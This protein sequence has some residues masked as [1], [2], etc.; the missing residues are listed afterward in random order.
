MALQAQDFES[1]RLALRARCPGLTA[2]DID[3]AFDERQLVISWLGR[4]TLHLVCA[5]DWAW[6][7]SLSAPR[8]LAGNRRRLAEEGVTADDADRALVVIERA[9]ADCGPSTR[10]DLR[11][12]VAAAGVRSEGQ[13]MVHLL[14]LAAFGGRIVRCDRQRY[15]LAADWLPVSPPVDRDAA[16]WELGLRYR[17]AHALAGPRDLAWWAGISLGEARIAWRDTSEPDTDSGPLDPK[18]LASFDE[19]VLGWK[20]RSFAIPERMRPQVF[21]G[22]IIRAVAT[23]DGEVVDTWTR[24]SGRVRLAD[25]DHAALFADEARD[26]ERFLA[27]T[28]CEND[29]PRD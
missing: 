18:L 12:L 23:V 21:A 17:A 6:L 7:L 13:A 25:G 4:G 22:G 19:Y 8:Q 29:P 26:V 27:G 10:E 9:L 16:L 11:P 5:E 1:A 15:A 20:D 24:P 3:R 28:V 2:G 14:G